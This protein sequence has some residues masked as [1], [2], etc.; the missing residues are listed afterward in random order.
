MI[1]ARPISAYNQG[2][3]PSKVLIL[4]QNWQ[5]VFSTFLFAKLESTQP[6]LTRTNEKFQLI[7]RAEFNTQLAANEIKNQY[8]NH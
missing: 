5:A 8:K 2:F 4:A 3:H 6:N 7:A 1:P